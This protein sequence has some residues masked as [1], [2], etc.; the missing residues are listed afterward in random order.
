MLARPNDSPL[1][2]NLISEVTSPKV[3]DSSRWHQLRPR[4]RIQESGRTGYRSQVVQD[5]VST[6]PHP[7]VSTVAVDSG[8]LKTLPHNSNWTP[9]FNSAKPH[10]QPLIK[11]RNSASLHFCNKTKATGSFVSRCLVPRSRL[12]S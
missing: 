8:V 1:V 2:I 7:Q 11:V 3:A 5:A 6:G 9:T 12:Q 4:D 10:R